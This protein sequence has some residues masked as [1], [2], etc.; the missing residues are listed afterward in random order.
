MS[1]EGMHRTSYA[2]LIGAAGFCA[3]ATL[4]LMRRWYG[5]VASIGA[6]VPSSLWVLA[7]VCAVLVVVV[8]RRRSDG[9]VGLDRSQL[10]PMMAANFMLFGKACAWAGAV[11]G[12]AYLG[13][14]VYV[15]PRLGTLTAAG[16]DLPGL[17]GVVVGGLLLA[18]A[19]VL[20]EKA[21]EV[22]PPSS[23]EGVS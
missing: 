5:A 11:C 13:P 15:V 7:L 19:G 18:V 6:A 1:S 14:L 21:C 20:L 16:E 12:G 23:G 22:S 2:A 17:I 4:I 8:K 10:N 3:A 9:R